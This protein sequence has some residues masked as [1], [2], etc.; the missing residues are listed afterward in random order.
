MLRYRCDSVPASS[1]V[2]PGKRPLLGI[3]LGAKVLKLA[4]NDFGYESSRRGDGISAAADA[5]YTA[6]SS[7]MS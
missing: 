1:A 4:D 2:W 5:S 6:R 3:R 7:P